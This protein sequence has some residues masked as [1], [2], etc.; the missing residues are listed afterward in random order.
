MDYSTLSKTELISIINELEAKNLDESRD[1]FLSNISHDVRTLLNAIYGNAQIMNSDDSLNAVHKKS[2]ERIIEA[3]SHM[4]DLI[5]NIISISKNRGDDKIILSEFNLNELLNNIYSIFKTVSLSNNLEFELNSKIDSTIII[6]TDK[7]KL[8]YILL[9]LVGNAIKYTNEGK[10]SINCDSIDKYIVFEIIDTGLGLNK[11]DLE[12]ISKEYVRGDNSTGTQGF[13]LGLGIVSKNLLLLDSE[14]KIVSEKKKGSTFSFKIKCKKDSKTF[15]STQN[16]I[17]DIKEIDFIKEPNDFYVLVYANN[18]DEVS[19]LGTYFNKRRIEYK[20]VDTL[21]SLKEELELNTVSMMF[22]DSSKLDKD[23]YLFFKEYKKSNKDI[24]FISLT[25][26][27]M[28]DDLT[29]INSISTTYIIE[30]YS[31]VDIDQSLI[32]FS[33]QE[34][35]FVEEV[36]DNT[37]HDIIIEEELKNKIIEESNLGNYKSCFGLIDGVGDKN[38]KKILLSYLENYDFDRIICILTNKNGCKYE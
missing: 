20:L 23:D 31:F 32:M 21:S 3:S 34:F 27:V 14:L 15:V 8:F 35:S 12:H 37:E 16:D 11:Q 7:T 33:S 5:N 6:K 22:I 38:S 1:L 36:S 28:N 9:N 24:P 26:S 30:P 10:V 2:V 18:E 19:I 25:S 4:I 29:R 13:G 17:F